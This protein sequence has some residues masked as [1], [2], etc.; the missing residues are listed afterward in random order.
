MWFGYCGMVC[1]VAIVVQGG[2]PVLLFWWGFMLWVFGL[3]LVCLITELWAICL[4]VLVY[5][6]GLRFC[7]AVLRLGC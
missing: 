6:D 7:L 5:L 4:V 2:T 3:R 1:F